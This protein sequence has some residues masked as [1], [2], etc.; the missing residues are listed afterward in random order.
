MTST[1]WPVYSPFAREHYGRGLDEGRAEGAAEE[2]ARM[3]MLVLGARGF[4]VPEDM[5]A[6]ISSCAD[7]A[8]LEGWATRAVTVQSLKELFDQSG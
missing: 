8:Q 7:L 5:R 1:D 2:A 6:R 3:L 4:H